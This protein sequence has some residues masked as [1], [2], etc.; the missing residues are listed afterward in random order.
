MNFQAHLKNMLEMMQEDI[1]VF[2]VGGIV[3]EL[4]CSITLGVLSGPL[5]GGYMVVMIL[6]LKREKRAEFN[7]LFAGLKRFGD[8]FPFFFL[9][10]LVMV[11]FVLLVIP[12]I[13]MTVWWIYVLP[14]MAHKG[15][16]LGEAMKLSKNKVMEK[17]FFLHLVFL[18]MISLVPVVI[19]TMAAAVVPPLAVLQYFLFPL[20]CACLA[21]LYLEQVENFDVETR[22]GA[23]GAGG[24]FT[25]SPPPVPPPMPPPAP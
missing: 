12:G 15:L 16:S 25:S 3:V 11:G 6:W 23:S 8:L 24:R 10:L 18:L 20:Q 7:D 4:L 2:F 17:G 22:Q 21:S 13:I 9:M 19:L 1:V 5:V 14:L